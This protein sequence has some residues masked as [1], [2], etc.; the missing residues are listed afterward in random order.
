[1]R[2]KTV[3]TLRDAYVTRRVRKD[4]TVRVAGRLWRPRGREAQ[5]GMWLGFFCDHDKPGMLELDIPG[6]DLPSDIRPA[7]IWEPVG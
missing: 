5:P 1:M 2:S 7:R 4:G 6:L 3:A